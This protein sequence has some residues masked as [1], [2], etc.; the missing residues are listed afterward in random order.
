V[1]F[2]I[3]KSRLLKFGK[4]MRTVYEAKRDRLASLGSTLSTRPALA[5][6]I[7]M[8]LLALLFVPY[9]GDTVQARFI[10]EPLQR[11]VVRA[12]VP[13]TVVDVLVSEGQPVELDHPVLRLRNLDLEG[14]QAQTEAD[15]QVARSRDVDSQLRY[16]SGAAAADQELRAAGQKNVLL[17]QQL[18][19]LLLRSPIRGNVVSPRP[20]DLLGSHLEAGAAAVEIADLSSLRARLYVPESEMREVRVGEKVSLRADSSFRSLPGVVSEIAAAG[21]QIEPGLEPHIVYKGL[22]PPPYY[23]VTVEEPNPEGKLMDGMTGLG[24]IRTGRRS[25]ASAIWRSVSDF[26]RRKL[27]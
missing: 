2:L 13:G 21:S 22:A 4:S 19:R 24:K 5:L 17:G 14:Q 18:D 26:V 27:W 12:Q 16:T 6:V 25:V 23:V 11:A 9:L 10:L 15:L 1:A 7:L 20:Q 3:F 8:A